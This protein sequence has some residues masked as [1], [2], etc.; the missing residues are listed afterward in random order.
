MR[1]SHDFLCFGT[2]PPPPPLSHEQII[3]RNGAGTRFI[4]CFSSR[5]DACS[6]AIAGALVDA[7][8]FPTPGPA[9]D[10]FCPSPGSVT[11]S[12]CGDGA[13]SEDA[14]TVSACSSFDTEDE[15]DR[16][17]PCATALSVD[18]ASGARQAVA[19][20][21]A[22]APKA[23]AGG[24]APGIPS[25]LV[26]VGGAKANNC[27]VGG[28]RAGAKRA[29]GDNSSPRGGVVALLLDE[30]PKHRL[31]NGGGDGSGGGNAG[32]SGFGGGDSGVVNGMPVQEWVEA[33]GEC[34][35]PMLA[36]WVFPGRGQ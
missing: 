31:C 14:R 20:E 32:T 7:A 4:V 1:N 27:S 2:C 24:T 28:G 6:S 33:Y 10:R 34:E 8:A 35:G 16:L 3:A 18:L 22:A 12:A 19:P 17:A 30:K 15:D 23:R 5:F 26:S 25:R 36:A 9:F 21:Q 29:N 11:V 13:I